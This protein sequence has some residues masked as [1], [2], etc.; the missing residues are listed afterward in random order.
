MAA[1]FGRGTGRAQRRRRDPLGIACAC[2]NWRLARFLLELGAKP[3][4]AD[5]AP[6]L[7]SAAGGDDD[8]ASGVQLLLKHK[9]RVD[10][11]DARGA[12]RCTRRRAPGMRASQT[13]CSKPARIRARD[14]DGRTP[15]LDARPGRQRRGRCPAR[16]RRQSRRSTTRAAAR[17]RSPRSQSC[18]PPRRCAACSRS[19]R[20]RCTPR[21]TGARRSTSRRR[22]AAG[23]VSLFDP[24]YPLPAS[25]GDNAGAAE[26]TAPCQ[27]L[28]RDGL[29]ERRTP[30]RGPGD[31]RAPARPA[32]TRRTA[33]RTAARAAHRCR[34]WLLAHGADAETRDADGDVPV[35][36]LL[37]RGPAQP[38]LQLYLRRA[39]SPAGRGGLARFLAACAGRPTS[40]LQQQLPLDLLDRGADPFGNSDAGD[41]PLALAV[42]LGWPRL[43]ARLVPIGVDTDARD[44]H[45]M[46]ALHLAAALGR[47]SML[48]QLVAA[49]ARP[50]IRA[51]DG[52]TPLGVALAGDSPRPRRLARLA[53]LAVAAARA[54]RR[55]PA[56]G[57]DRRRHR[58]GAPPARTRL[59]H[60]HRRRAGVAPRCCARPAA[61]IA[62]PP[63]CC[64]RAASNPQLAANTGA[65]PLSAA[66]S[67]RH[68]EVVERLLGAGASLEQRLPGEVTVLMLAS[69]LGLPDVRA[70]A[71]GRRR[72]A[73][74][75]RAGLTRCTARRCT[76]SPRASARACSRCWIRCC[77]PAPN[78]TR[79][80]LAG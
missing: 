22:R 20:T 78:P 57:R 17:S 8:D 14:G 69:A 60:R 65:T 80:R 33:A 43:C 45:G 9:A 41:P 51:A 68:V 71:R 55:G 73:R 53:R 36:A 1:R 27:S 77:S 42:R 49:G 12:A 56:R 16:G 54:A 34:R 7:L 72:R 35:L 11:R 50:D 31:A 67:M 28:L 29:V 38:V 39:L 30:D 46:A 13:R 2:G 64:S 61:A 59:R 76:A 26:E 21:A 70:P 23:L 5:A 32:R 6:A 10:A 44:A 25:V 24:E 63:S 62:P 75:R 18:R 40:D 48:K 19:A 3:E 15:L 58:R 66:V 47:E 79:S 52:R 4:A 37:A 74:R